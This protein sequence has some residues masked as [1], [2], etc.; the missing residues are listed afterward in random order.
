MRTD[1]ILR[2]ASRLED[3][4]R[5]L[6]EIAG[7]NASPDDYLTEAEAAAIAKCSVRVLRD[8]RR[9]GALPMFGKQRSRGIRRGH[10]SVWIESRMAPVVKGA[11]DADIE[12]RVRRIARKARKRSGGR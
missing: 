7:L 9:S 8:A 12:Q 10:L 5:E 1:R 3:E 4:A 11:N 2:L 6:R